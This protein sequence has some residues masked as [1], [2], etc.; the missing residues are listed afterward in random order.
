MFATLA[1]QSNQPEFLPEFA[2]NRVA[3][4]QDTLEISHLNRAI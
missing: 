4:I 1:I 2:P 3:K